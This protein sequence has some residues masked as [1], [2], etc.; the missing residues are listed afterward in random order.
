MPKLFSTLNAQGNYI[1][2]PRFNN[3]TLLSDGEFGF[4]GLYP[5]WRTSGVERALNDVRLS[6][7]NVPN[8]DLSMNFFRITN[9]ASPVNDNDVATQGWV[10]NFLRGLDVKESVKASPTTNL[11]VTQTGNILTANAN[12]EIN[13]ESI[14]FIVGDDILLTEQTDQ[15]QNGIFVITDLG[16]VSTPFVLERRIDADTNSKV[17]AGMYTFVE[18]GTRQGEGYVLISTNI[19]LNSTNLVFTKFSDSSIFTIGNGLLL[20][21]N[22]LSIISDNTAIEVKTNSIEF[23][24][25][26]TSGLEILA[27]GVQIA[28]SVAGNGLDISGKVLSVSSSIPR[29]RNFTITGNGTSTSFTVNHN[30]DK[31][32][33]VVQ[34]TENSTDDDIIVDVNK[35]STTSCT[36]EFEQPVAN[37]VTYNVTVVG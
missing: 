24:I 12:G 4:T 34:V 25:T 2:R 13:I 30:L 15:K 18:E 14:P 28:D 9:V 10:K 29:I 5:K 26:G 27:G 20:S 31:K 16:S 17:T 19:N 32:N 11:D 22:T 36:I 8:T 35:T 1:V 6:E 33:V 23:K 7:F 3:D 37:G 21:S